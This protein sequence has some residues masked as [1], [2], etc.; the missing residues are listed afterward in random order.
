MKKCH[1]FCKKSNV[2]F[3]FPLV[4][5]L[6]VGFQ[7]VRWFFTGV[8]LASSPHDLVASSPRD[9]SPLTGGC[10]LPGSLLHCIS[11]CSWLCLW[12]ICICRSSS[13]SW[14][15]SSTYSRAT[16]NHSTAKQLGRNFLWLLYGLFVFSRECNKLE[17]Y[18]G[19][20]NGALYFLCSIMYVLHSR[21]S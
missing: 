9:S 15:I 16:S 8:S 1:L 21:V 12:F 10:K 4:F 2:F 13:N 20:L 18:Y 3:F 14:D 7:R 17:V 19:F 6:F 5:S 11:L